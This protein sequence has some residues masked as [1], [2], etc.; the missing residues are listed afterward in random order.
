MLGG[1]TLKIN[2]IVSPPTG[3]HDIKKGKKEKG[4]PGPLH[5][6]DSPLSFFL[7][8]PFHYWDVLQLYCQLSNI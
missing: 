8:H 1:D 6:P 7:R 5:G 2:L 4:E 3:V